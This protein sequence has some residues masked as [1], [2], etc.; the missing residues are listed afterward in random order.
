MDYYRKALE[1]DANNFLANNN[2][3]NL[4]LDHGGNVDKALSLAQ[5]ARELAPDHPYVADTLGWIYCKKNVYGKAL[6]LLQEA[7]AKIKDNPVLHYHLG[8]AYYGNGQKEAAVKELKR[9]LLLRKDF[10]GAAEALRIVKVL[11][12]NN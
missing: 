12:V 10:T 11:E 3:A 1:I 5:T 6:G 2:L 4:Y 8:V 7:Q 9:A